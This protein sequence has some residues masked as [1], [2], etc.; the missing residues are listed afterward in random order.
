MACFFKICYRLARL[1]NNDGDDSGGGGDNSAS[2]QY[3][4]NQG[5]PFFDVQNP[6][7]LVRVALLF[8]VCK[9]LTSASILERFHS[10]WRLPSPEKFCV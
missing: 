8:G 4:W 6:V 1:S 10:V 3:P 2:I 5:F 7:L 9:S